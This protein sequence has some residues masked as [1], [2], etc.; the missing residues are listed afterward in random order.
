MTSEY[1]QVRVYTKKVG[2]KPDFGDPVILSA[3][4]GGTLLEH[5]CR[6][7]HNSMVAQLNYALVWGTSSKHYPQRYVIAVILLQIIAS[8]GSCSHPI[9]SSH[10]SHSDEQCFLTL[11]GTGL[12][13]A[14]RDMSRYAS[15]S[16]Q[17]PGCESFKQRLRLCAGL[18]ARL[19]LRATVACCTSPLCVLKTVR[20]L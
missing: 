17:V 12:G 3:D 19:P 7:I 14:L 18:L 4:R 5:L 8:D 11:N 9:F 1:S 2:A 16:M 13:I 10:Y 15:T 20:G 6:Q